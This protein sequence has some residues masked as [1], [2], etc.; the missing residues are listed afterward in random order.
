MTNEAER[1]IFRKEHDPYMD[2]D[3][4]LA[5][6]P[7]D[8]VNPGRIGAVSCWTDKNGRFWVDPYDEIDLSYYYKQK[9]IH[10]NDPI[11]REIKDKLEYAFSYKY[12]P[13]KLRICEKR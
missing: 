3:K 6:F 13:L 9:I 1:V 4:V 10:K 12:C 11:A 5:C 2:I 7:D 8:E